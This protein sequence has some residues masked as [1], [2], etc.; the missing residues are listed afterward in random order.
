MQMISRVVDRRSEESV[1]CLRS[2]NIEILNVL[3][4]GDSLVSLVS[5]LE[6]ITQLRVI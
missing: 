6:L 2:E 5:K 3:T 4:Y 1:S